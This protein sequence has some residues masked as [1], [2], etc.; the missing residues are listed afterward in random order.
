VKQ[1]TSSQ[2]IVTRYT[3]KDTDIISGIFY[4]SEVYPC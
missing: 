3:F 1:S 4:L 2:N